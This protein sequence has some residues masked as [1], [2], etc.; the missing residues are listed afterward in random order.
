MAALTPTKQIEEL[1]KRL[2][3]ARQLVEDGTVEGVVGDHSHY[4]VKAGAGGFYL[5]NGHCTCQ[6]AR[7]RRDIHKGWCKHMLAV[8]LFQETQAEPVAEPVA[9][10]VTDLE[11]EINALFGA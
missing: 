7:F 5:V 1:S 4:L 10:P 9:V 11:D 2:E 6:D 8:S 3:R